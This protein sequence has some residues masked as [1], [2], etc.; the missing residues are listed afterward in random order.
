[1]ASSTSEGGRYVRWAW[2]RKEARTTASASHR[3][4]PSAISQQTKIRAAKGASPAQGFHTSTKV[5]ASLAR[6]VPTSP[7]AT[8]TANHQPPI[9]RATC[10]VSAKHAEASRPIVAGRVQAG[11]NRAAGASTT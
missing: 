9:R 4:L 6:M 10:R 3:R 5:A 1:M 7:T 11:P 8:T 2:T